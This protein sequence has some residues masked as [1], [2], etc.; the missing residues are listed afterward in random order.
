MTSTTRIALVQALFFVS[1]FCGL[2]YESIW[3]HYLKLFLGH[4]AYAQSVVLVVFIGGMAIGAGA[5]GRHADRIRRPLLAYAAAEFVVGWAGIAFHAVFTSTTGWAYETLLP[6][7][8]SADG[9]CVS[10]WLLAALLILPQSILLG[11][12]FPLMTSGLLRLAPADP[13]RRIALLYFLNSLGAVAGVLASVFVLIPLV[14]LPG[15]SFAAGATNILLALAVGAIATSGT[16]APV[17]QRAEGHAASARDPGVSVRLLLVV[18]ALTGLASF[19]YEIAWIRMLSLVLGASTHAFELMLASFIL[20]LALGGAWIRR[21]IDRLASPRRF[22]GIVQV[23][24]GLAALGS[25]VLYGR[26][27]DAMAWLLAA[28]TKTDGGY[29]LF[30]LGSAGIAMAIML[31]A[32]F[33]AGMTLP[34]I[35]FI[36]LRG[37]LGERA[38]GTVYAWNTAGAIAGVL[39][40]V[41][42]GL[43]QLGI[44]GTLI[45]G[46]AIDIL[47]GVALLVRG[48]TTL[49]ARGALA[50]AAVGVLAVALAPWVLEID[51][52]RAIAG[53]YRS[54]IAAIGDD[55]E[56][57]F[58]RD[59]KTASVSVV[60]VADSLVSIKTNG[61]P[62]GSA[63][64]FDRGDWIS[65]DE[66][67]MVLS[68][69]LPLARVPDAR[70]VAVIGYGTG[71]TTAA[72]L[73]MPTIATVDTIEIEPAMI[74]GARH[75]LPLTE[76]A[77]GDPRGR[78][79]IDDAKS[80]FAKAGRRY[81]IIVS[82]PSNP[83]VAGVSSLFTVEFYR[84]VDRHLAPGGVLAQWI[85][86][87]EFDMR[88]LS[89]VVEAVRL[90]FPDVTIYNVNGSDLILIAA[91]E[92]A[93]PRAGRLFEH[94][95]FAARLASVGI[96][97]P[98]EFD[99]RRVVG[100]V[101]LGALFGGER[102]PP[103]SDYFPIVD[104]GAPGA[105]FKGSSAV[106]AIQLLAAPVPVVDL[107]ERRAPPAASAALPSLDIVGI[108]D[109]WAGARAA[110]AFVT[111][112]DFAREAPIPPLPSSRAIAQARVVLVDCVTPASATLAWDG[113]VM[114]AGDFAHA[115][116]AED[117][118]RFV[119][120]I[121]RSAC[122]SRMPEA[123]A[124]WVRLFRAVARRDASA[125]AE[126][127]G[128]LAARDDLSALQRD[129]VTLAAAAGLVGTGRAP[130]A[131]R[132]LDTPREHASTDGRTLAAYRFV[133]AA[134]RAPR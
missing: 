51:P 128:A 13:G 77:Y 56:I 59:G 126:A 105:R 100:P 71:L 72:F 66:A 101:A 14:G 95:A 75:F 96:A 3:S 63:N 68:A 12:T 48:G 1:G 131:R 84:Q 28:L 65:A 104:I 2:I 64:I 53:V 120:T 117:F 54:G 33:A 15:A 129:Y 7:T 22:L 116:G 27:F 45:A 24:M 86:A 69:A 85:Q 38:I 79:V 46:A 88:L 70:D 125:A 99:R 20:G 103:N 115:L 26:S 82:E 80:F 43:P 106:D 61:K 81:D 40:A 90:V 25:L 93:E 97:S 78:L 62:D 110:Q 32:T 121:E 133:E 5:A 122:R 67:T 23:A 98:D 29:L 92:P 60:R 91:R 47:L 19:V 89:S 17:A 109:R 57:L 16:T 108:A 44:K 113:V 9:W 132:L 111:G 94:P 37:R 42:V 134:A 39:V 11:T 36:L 35:T 49:R 76:R 18:A 74:E 52:R 30:N 58:H 50:F 114:L 73:D 87:Y 34:L 123:T 83:W 6:A 102:S 10:S 31:P 118:E 4:A 41:H 130:E 8:C 55:Q 21:R 107:V 127:G 124:D 119:A 112:P